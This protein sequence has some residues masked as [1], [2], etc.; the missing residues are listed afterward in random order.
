M[1]TLSP[2]KRYL[3]ATSRGRGKNSGYISC[4]L[5][6]EEGAVVKKMF[7]MPTGSYGTTT[8]SLITAPWSDKI[9]LYG[10]A[11]SGF[12]A[13][14]QLVGP[15]ETDDGLEYSSAKVISRLDIAPG[16]CCSNALWVD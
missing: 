6:D 8:S 4:F 3:W 16:S 12:L 11:P 1:L 7:M 2:N 13:V 14:L 5:L 9:A 10:D 15:V